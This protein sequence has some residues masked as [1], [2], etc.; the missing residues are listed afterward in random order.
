MSTPRE[1]RP[2][3]CKKH[4]GTFFLGGMPAGKRFTFRI[5]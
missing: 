4:L 3:L 1:K 2:I 5:K